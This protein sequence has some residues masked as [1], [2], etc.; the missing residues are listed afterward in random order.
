MKYGDMFDATQTH[1]HAYEVIQPLQGMITF[2]DVIGDDD[3]YRNN[4]SGHQRRPQQ[5]LPHGKWDWI[6]DS[7]IYFMLLLLLIFVFVML[8]NVE[9]QTAYNDIYLTY[10]KPGKDYLTYSVEKAGMTNPMYC[11][12][13][14][15]NLVIFSVIIG[16]TSTKRYILALWQ[17]V[18]LAVLLF[19]LQ[20]LAFMLHIMMLLAQSPDLG[21]Y[22]LTSVSMIVLHSL[23]LIL[24]LL[25]LGL[26]LAEPQSNKIQ[27]SDKTLTYEDVQRETVGNFWLSVV[28]DLNTIL[29]YAF[30][31]LACNAQSFINDDSTTFFDVLCV[32]FLGFLQHV[33]N[34]LMIFHAH[35]SKKTQL[36]MKKM[37]Q[38]KDESTLV[39]MK[40]QMSELMDFIARTRLFSFFMVLATLL[41]FLL[42]VAPTYKE[43]EYAETYKVFR[44]LAV[45]TMVLLNTAQSCWFEIQSMTGRPESWETS[46][47]WKLGTLTVIAFAMCFTVFHNTRTDF[48]ADNR[49]LLHKLTVR[50]T[51]SPSATSTPAPAPLI[52]S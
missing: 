17:S 18:G 21:Y 26:L 25:G 4:L 14:A 35:I 45:G 23:T 5:K 40:K 3:E 16:L 48:H 22:C 27:R 31:V 15:L 47:T 8:A 13:I 1:Q 11:I 19:L 6:I 30:V 43:Y 29:C 37:S 12:L 32:V 28:E 44:G 9:H 49:Y 52:G 42:R 51:P 46:P 39:E 20:V 50:P 7:F 33:A 24:S 36:D 34:I 2:G 10:F 41:F 38:Q